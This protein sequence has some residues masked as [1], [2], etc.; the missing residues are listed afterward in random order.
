MDSN[1]KH[2]EQRRQFNCPKHGF[3]MIIVMRYDDT[4]YDYDVSEYEASECW[5]MKSMTIERYDR[6]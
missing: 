4:K 6:N 3:S 2:V 5:C 1:W